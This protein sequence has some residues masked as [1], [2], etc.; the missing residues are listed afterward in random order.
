MVVQRP[1]DLVTHRKRKPRCWFCQ[2][3][4]FRHE[5]CAG[6][7]RGK[8]EADQGT[9]CPRL[10]SDFD[11]ASQSTTGSSVRKLKSVASRLAPDCSLCNTLLMNSNNNNDH[12]CCLS[13]TRIGCRKWHVDA[14]VLAWA[15]GARKPGS[16]KRKADFISGPGDWLLALALRATRGCLPYL[17]IQGVECFYRVA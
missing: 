10:L 2:R 11:S 12:K 8:R 14:R 1:V 6:N 17:W 7:R 4:A 9:R 3:I 13:C 16:T 5:W 15:A